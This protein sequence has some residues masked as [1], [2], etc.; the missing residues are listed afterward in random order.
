MTK[1]LLTRLCSSVDLIE[2]DSK[3]VEQAKT[4]EY[5]RDL[6]DSK[7]IGRVYELGL[8]DWYPDQ[9]TYGMDWLASDCI[10]TC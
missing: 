10:F 8:Q 4:G 2:Q 7:K 3:F 6:R 5:L 9:G 1:G